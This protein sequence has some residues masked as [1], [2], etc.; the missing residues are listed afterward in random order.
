MLPILKRHAQSY[1]GFPEMRESN[2][3]ESL[4]ISASALRHWYE[5]DPDGARPA[6][7]T[8]ISRPR[9]RFGARLLG[10]LPHETLPEVDFTPAEQLHRE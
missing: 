1:H 9:P 8:E 5:L 3:Y 6:I 10:I 4:E 2:A 7:I